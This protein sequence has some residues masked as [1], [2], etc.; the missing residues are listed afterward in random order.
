MTTAEKVLAALQAHGLKQDGQGK[1]RCNSPL[2]PGSNSHGFCVVIHP[3]GEHGAYHDKVTG[4][5]GSLYTLAETLGIG[6]ERQQAADT[7]RTYTGLVDYADAHGVPAEAYIKA[8]WAEVEHHCNTLEKDR[9]ALSIPTVNGTRYRYLDGEKPTYNSPFGYK[10]CWYGLQR[11]IVMAR[12][13]SQAIV[14]CNGSPSVVAAQY[15]GVPAAALAQGNEKIPVELLNELTRSWQGDIIIAMDCDKQGRK[16]TENYVGQLPKAQIVD[17]GLTAGG[18]LAD[19][20][21]LYGEDSYEKLSFRAVRFDVFANMQETL[22][23]QEALREL[24]AARKLDERKGEKSIGELLDATQR[25]LDRLRGKVEPGRVVTMAELVSE[26]HKALAERRRNPNPIQGLRSNFPTLDKSLGGWV[27]G[28]VHML[29]GDTN[30]GKSTLAVSIL[31]RWIEQGPGLIIPTES[32]ARAYLDKIAANRCKLRYDLI[33]TGSL[34]DEE[35]NCVVSQYTYLEDQQCRIVDVGSPT[36]EY[37]GAVLRDMRRELD[38]KWVMIDSISKMKLAYST[39]IYE[40]MRISADAIQ[41]YAREYNVPFLVTCQIGRNLK[42]RSVKVPQL[43]DALGAGTIEQNADVVM[44]LYNHNHYVKQGLLDPDPKFPEDSALLRIIKHRW[45]DA[46][47]TAVMLK[48]VGGSGF[49]EMET[50]QP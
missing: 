43:N 5:A 42:D 7:K 29:Y 35:Y 12:D 20:C 31:A 11:A 14:L 13:K 23:L 9:P 6:I 46:I 36:P 4:E 48:F 38:F 45:R 32:P 37:L 49:Y 19:F 41:D 16:A 10:D 17:L 15:W 3:D 27:G 39:D 47:N 2:R 34:T 8:G 44:S 33:E 30:M 25:E 18:D 28:R 50:H 22:G 26:N 24:T 40:T 21:H 1:Y